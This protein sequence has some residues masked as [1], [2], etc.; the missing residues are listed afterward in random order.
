VPTPFLLLACAPALD[1][2]GASETCEPSD[3]QDV[4]STSIDLHLDSLF[5]RARLEV[6]PARG[7][8]DVDLDVSGLSVER[9]RVDGEAVNG[10]VEG[11][12]LSVAAGDEPVVIDVDYHFPEREPSTFDGWMPSLGVTFIWPYYCSNLFPCNPALDDGVRFQM[13]VEGASGEAIYPESIPT[14]APD[15]M[16]AVAVG[17]YVRIDL[18]STEAGTALSAYHFPGEEQAANAK[19]GTAHLVDAFD[20]FERTYGPYAF[21]PDVATVEVDWGID[22]WGGMEHHPYYH[23]GKWDFND[24]EAQVHEAGHGWY[25][26]GVRLA[27]WEDFV[28]SE[29]TNSYITAR[30]LEQVGGPS[31][32]DYYVD[33]FLVPACEGRDVNTIVLPDETCNEI[34]FVNDDL[35]SLATYMK[36]ACFYEEVADAIGPEK[37]DEIIGEFYMQHVNG[38]ARMQEMIDLINESVDASG[39]A[40]VASAETDWL[41]T[42]ACPSDYAN[43]CRTHQR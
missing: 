23:V 25:G 3:V 41:R 38:A 36:G 9:V 27:C 2:T 5:G 31:E 34:D 11:G 29:G 15:Y 37:L 39:R 26:N 6:C 33:G 12:T 17:D 18:G 22:S 42:K 13:S 16:P 21:G 28:L 4:R 8:S 35:W 10:A 1:D 20:F 43:R 30:A 14:D 19:E 24:E 40:A 32:W 7:R